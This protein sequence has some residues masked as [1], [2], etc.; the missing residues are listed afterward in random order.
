MPQLR[1]SLSVRSLA[2]AATMSLAGLSAHAQGSPASISGTIALPT[3]EVI[4][5]ATIVVTDV[6]KGIQY[7][8][9][10]SSS[11]SY[12]LPVLPVGDYRMLV[13]AP[14]Y[15]SAARTGLTLVIDQHLDLNF[16]LTAGE[17]SEMVTVSAGAPQLDTETHSN[18]TVIDS[19][20]IEQ[21]PLNSRTF[22]SLALLVPGVMPP[23]SNSSLGYRGGFN[24]AGAPESANDF[25]LDGFDNNNE[26]VNIPGYRPSVDAIEEFKVLTGL[27]SAEF[28]RDAG[29]QVLVTG[30]SGSNAFHGLAYEYLRNQLFDAKNYTIQPG[31]KPSFKRNQFGGTFGGPIIHDRTFFFFNYEGLRLHQQLSVLSSVPTA[32]MLGGDFSALL[33]GTTKVQLKNPFT[34]AAIANNRINSLAQ[35][36]TPAAVIGQALAS[37]YPAPTNTSVGSNNAPSNNYNF[38][39]LRTELSNQYGLR[40][41]HTLSKKDSLYAEYNYFDDPSFEPYNSLCGPRTIPGFGCYSGVGYQ[42][43]GISETHIFSPNVVNS[44]RA[45]YTRYRQDRQQQDAN[46]NFIGQYGIPNVFLGDTPGNLGL[47]QTAI[48]G[49]ATLGG[50]SNN[51]QDFINNEMQGVDQLI[52]TQHHHTLKFGADIRR[53]QQNDLSVLTGRGAFTFTA[54]ASA[55]T[56][57]YALADLLLGLPTTSS[58]NPYAPKIYV[59]TTA[60]DGYVQD[61]WKA[62]PT[63]TVN[64]GL[65]WE[66]NT[67]FT[68]LHDQQSTFIPAGSGS[69][70]RAGLGGVGDNLIQYD[71]TKFEP[72][73]GFSYAA[74]SKT[75]LRGGYGLYSSAP[76]S[77]SGIGNLF[78]NAPM[79]NPQTFNNSV[80]SGVC[81]SVTT[82]CTAAFQLN[83]PF[84]TN[85]TSSSAPY[86]IDYHFL[87]PYIQQFG[88]GI[89]RQL[90]ANTLLD[91]SYFGSKGT[92]LPNQININEATPNAST[93]TA[94]ANARRPY[95]NFAN[96][97]WY[98][99]VGASNF[100]SLL[101]KLDKRLSHGLNLLISYSYAHSLDNTP[102]FNSSNASN[103]QPQNSSDLSSEYGSS[104]F[105]IRNRLTVSSVYELPFGRGR[106]YLDHG[107]GAALAGGWQLSGIYSQNSARPFTVYFSSNVS[108][109]LNVHD[110]PNV[111]GDVNAGPHTATAWFNAAAFTTA[112]QTTGTFGNERRNAV[113]GPRSFDLDST[114]SRNFTLPERL[115]LQFRAEFFNIL[116]HPN[117]DLPNATIGGTGYNT[118]STV[119]DPRQLQ[120]ALRLNF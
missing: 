67:P 72:R 91:V 63:L 54:S 93:S 57:G 6:A 9:T 98:Q 108:N 103:A 80:A 97:L 94:L 110:R 69:V 56:T 39:A 43:G 61:D 44:L 19:Q 106:S 12:A 37:Y 62:T 34:G 3:G 71:Y 118:I 4:P 46:I 78:Y 99:S 31:Y 116:N 92:H 89:Q 22:Y 117:F 109:T 20:K 45:G 66:L 53:N 27:Y 74:G 81:T 42:L 28:G 51:P 114:L 83:N 1:R 100:N 59:R 30:K 50:P 2:L 111:I 84:P 96:I 26:Q 16:A 77:F 33:A 60:F 25:I 73:V 79:R 58:N 113:K 105:D 82:P 75:V 95:P 41:D 115:N 85:L 11:G 36:T 29:G 107:I 119:A 48:S 87:N 64:M 120:L 35:F 17:V 76:A 38:N 10:S 32:A 14:G 18:G 104:D 47:P 86:G 7:T 88:V 8:A 65:R 90:T 21:L 5:N 52:W 112:A 70:V 13:T 101:A 49:Y 68:A 102:G 55:P 15:K 23:A 40:I 24:V